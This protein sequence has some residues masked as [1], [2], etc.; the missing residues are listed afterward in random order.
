MWCEKLLLQAYQP[1]QWSR[2]R[3]QQRAASEN[4]RTS[5]ALHKAEVTRVWLFFKETRTVLII[6]YHINKMHV[7]IKRHF[8]VTESFV[9]TAVRMNSS[10]TSCTGCCASGVLCRSKWLRGIRQGSSVIRL[11]GLRLRIP[12]ETWMCVSCECCVLQ[13]RDLGVGL[14]TRSEESYRVWCVWILTPWSRVLLEKL[15]GL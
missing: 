12:S 9:H 11:L 1:I 15:I 10:R 13:S 8:H 5:R 7:S 4:Q 2:L 6:L 3:L 14:I